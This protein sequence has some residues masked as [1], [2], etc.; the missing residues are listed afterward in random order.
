M[1]RVGWRPCSC[2]AHVTNTRGVC[3]TAPLFPIFKKCLLQRLTQAQ[4]RVYSMSVRRED[5][6][7][8]RERNETVATY[9]ALTT[10]NAQTNGW[11]VLAL[12]GTKAEAQRRGDAAIGAGTDIFTDT[13]RKNL[14]VLSET[15]AKRQGFVNDYSISEWLEA[16]QNGEVGG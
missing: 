4:T 1:N 7:R 9:Y 6:P 10:T 5:R 3:D 15:A 14:T 12:A 2:R 11:E 8:Q 16:W 13:R